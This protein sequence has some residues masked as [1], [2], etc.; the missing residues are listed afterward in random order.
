MKFTGRL[1]ALL[2]TMTL[3]QTTQADA[4][5]TRRTIRLTTFNVEW[6]G[7]GGKKEGSSVDEHR[8]ASLTQFLSEKVMPTDVISFQE[9]IDLPRLTKLLPAGWTC[10]SYD[11]N[12][13]K[14]QHVALCAAPAFSL[15]KV[16]YDD[17]NIIDEVAIQPD[18]YRPAVRMN[19]VDKNTQ[20][21]LTTV[22]GVH[23]KAMPQYTLTRQQQIQMI[24]TDLLKNKAGRPTVILGDFNTFTKGI[25]PQLKEDDKITLE[26]TLKKTIPS[27]K[28]IK[29]VDTF[30]YMNGTLGAQFD[31]FYVNKAKVLAPPHV[32]GAC[33]DSKET[34]DFFN[35]YYYN[36]W[37]SDHCPTYIDIQI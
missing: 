23:L 9:I 15:E 35:I 16:E 32:F 8:D 1:L 20:Q 5:K 19:L 17:N 26:K 21:V 6:Y 2:A 18:R 36:T 30:T 25:V 33:N 13:P 12:N 29:H 37:V 31:Q 28:L 11:T 4:G 34:N 3:V 27:F 14:H 24:A 22:V 7:L 10:A